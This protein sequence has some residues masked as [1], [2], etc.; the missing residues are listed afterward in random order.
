MMM[1][2]AADDDAAPL[3][4]ALLPG[5]GGVEI[6]YGEGVSRGRNSGKVIAL[7][8]DQSRHSCATSLEGY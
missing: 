1:I 6:M 8:I 7:E 5:S 3:S 4:R 2:G